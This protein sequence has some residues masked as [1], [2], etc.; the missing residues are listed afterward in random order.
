MTTLLIFEIGTPLLVLAAFWLGFSMGRE[1]VQTYRFLLRDAVAEK[2]H[3]R[4]EAR[5]Y[6]RELN[7]MHEKFS[8]YYE[9]QYV[10]Q[11]IP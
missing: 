10:I 4:F 11:E 7:D 8:W 6:K 2:D 3:W 5:A 9:D 1:K